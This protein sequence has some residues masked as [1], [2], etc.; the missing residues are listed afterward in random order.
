MELYAA[1]G[2]PIVKELVAEG[3]Q[4]FLDLKLYDISETVK[5]AT[6]RVAA[7]GARFL[8]IH[9]S[10]AL[11]RAAREGSGSSGLQLLAVSVLTSFSQ[12]DVAD[13][14]HTRSVEDLVS[15]RVRNAVACGMDGIIC[16]PL[17]AASV[18]AIAGPD[19]LI[20]TP[21]V[22][23]RTTDTGDQK[24]F[25]TP[26]EAIAA[27]ANYLVIGR[28]VTRAADPVAEVAKIQ[29]ELSVAA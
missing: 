23:S 22:R 16:S 10:P 27:G 9:S 19:T 26:A 6:A 11:M 18:R 1:E 3:K 21:G 17:E 20:V 24:R 5:R 15:L 14:G 7:S 4:V 29:A 12:Q 28:Q 25:A 8:T 2:M 13:L